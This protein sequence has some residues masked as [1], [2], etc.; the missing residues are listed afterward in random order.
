MPSFFAAAPDFAGFRDAIAT[1][2]D[3]SLGFIAGMTF[4]S[5]ML[6]AP[7]M[8]QRT[9]WYGG[10]P[11]SV[12]SEMHRMASGRRYLDGVADSNRSWRGVD[13]VLAEQHIA[14]GVVS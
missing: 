5:A 6:A 9:G 11:W 2:V 4:S 10:I 12:A 13:H 1:T 14:L 8:P 3:R 7:R